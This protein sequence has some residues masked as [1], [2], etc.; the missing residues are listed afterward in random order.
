MTS[1]DKA[2]LEVLEAYLLL[3]SRVILDNQRNKLFGL[4]DKN[5][6]KLDAYAN[7]RIRNFDMAQYAMFR[8]IT[9]GIYDIR[10][11]MAS[12]AKPVDTTRRLVKTKE[13]LSKLENN[14]NYFDYEEDY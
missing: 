3:K 13:D 1:K 10:A 8:D 2:L 9:Q 14:Y 4:I 7:A 6:K 11:Q 5:S 12:I